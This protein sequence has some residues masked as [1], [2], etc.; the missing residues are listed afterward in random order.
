MWCCYFTHHAHLCFDMDS[1]ADAH[2]VFG[3]TAVNYRCWFFQLGLVEQ[4]AE[5]DLT[6]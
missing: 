6:P 5:A 2:P 4:L 3:C 1:A